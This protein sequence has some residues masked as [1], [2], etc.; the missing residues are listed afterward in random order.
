MKY[1]IPFLTAFLLCLN[2]TISAQEI[3]NELFI[4]G[5]NGSA[6]KFKLFDRVYND[7]GRIFFEI[8]IDSTFND[9]LES[10]DFMDLD[11][12]LDPGGRDYIFEYEPGVGVVDY[13]LLKNKYFRDSYSIDG[14]YMA[15]TSSSYDNAI[16]GHAIPL[17]DD[18]PNAGDN[19]VVY[20]MVNDSIL[21]YYEDTL[22]EEQHFYVWDEICIE[23]DFL[24][25][26]STYWDTH[27]FMGDTLGNLYPE[28]G[29]HQYST[30]LHK[31]NWRTNEKLWSK[32]MEGEEKPERVREIEVIDDGTLMIAIEISRPFTFDGEVYDPPHFIN[33]GGTSP[34]SNYNMVVAKISQD[35][36]YINH[37]HIKAEGDQAIKDVK[38]E[39]TGEVYAY[40]SLR[41]STYVEFENDTITFDRITNYGVHG[42]FFAFDKNL[43]LQYYKKYIS[44]DI[45]WVTGAGYISNEN[46][47]INIFMGDSITIEDQVY[48]TMYQ[49]PDANFTVPESFLVVFDKEG[50]IVRDPIR[51][52]KEY[53]IS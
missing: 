34:V 6:T 15:V 50:N 18:L 51:I 1:Y 10:D 36:E 26:A 5:I 53:K 22:W 21:W 12:D 9:A 39:D 35:G 7:K 49:D 48:Y 37:I 20:D 31:I 29:Q 14:D 46:I 42:I 13:T 27:V 52:G 19:L 24:Y 38:L 33:G 43:D 32:H 30:M 40:G 11:F 17:D 28:Y 41:P 25:Y 16:N 23:G 47:G 8:R 4:R 44:P 45:A 2:T 3:V